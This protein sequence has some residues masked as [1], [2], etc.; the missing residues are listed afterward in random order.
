MKWGDNGMIAPRLH[1]QAQ[2]GAFIWAEWT[3]LYCL[4]CRCT[5]KGFSSF[6]SLSFDYK[7]DSGLKED[8]EEHILTNENCDT[9]NDDDD[10]QIVNAGP[11]PATQLLPLPS[12][13]LPQTSRFTLI[14]AM[15]S[16]VTM[17][18][19]VVADVDNLDD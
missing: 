8:F 9:D 19:A 10:V 15:I 3:G 5:V 4:V 14:I 17:K 6:Q 11:H 1:L 18:I 12:P 16:V 7:G 13:L 2:G